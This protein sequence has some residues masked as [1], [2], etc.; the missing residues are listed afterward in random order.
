MSRDNGQEDEALLE[1]TQEAMKL[2]LENGEDTKSPPG[3]IS[4]ADKQSMGVLKGI[5]RI[6][7]TEDYKQIL[8]LSNFLD[9]H[10]A[11]KVAAACEEAFRY[12]LELRPILDWCICQCAVCTDKSLQG[13]S[14]AHMGLQG[15]V[16]R[17]IT[18]PANLKRRQEDD[19][20]VQ[21]Y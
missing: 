2:A 15:V 21:A 11:N 12:D 8:Y 13:M 1:T 9:Y 19:R 17:E 4:E 7:D 10:Q 20:K 14:R 18:Y 6:E 16:K 3:A 5:I